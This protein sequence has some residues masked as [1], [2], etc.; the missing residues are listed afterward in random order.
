[1]LKSLE[2]PWIA[3]LAIAKLSNQFSLQG[4]APCSPV[5]SAAV[6]ILADVQL[7]VFVV[8]EKMLV[9][10]ILFDLLKYLHLTLVL[11]PIA[12][13]AVIVYFHTL[14]AVWAID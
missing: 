13:F 1:M 2:L 6:E 8:L 12:S 11:A 9:Q 7:L 3:H 5:Q 10:L 14:H 4:P